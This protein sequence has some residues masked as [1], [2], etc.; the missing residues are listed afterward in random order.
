MK[1]T[2]GT[3][4]PEWTGFYSKVKGYL[5][6]NCGSTLQTQQAVRQH[7]QDGHFDTPVYNDLSED[8]KGGE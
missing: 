3:F 1:I 8:R 5:I 2:V 6:C 4:R 7:W